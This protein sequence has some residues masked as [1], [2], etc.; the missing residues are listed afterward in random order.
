MSFQTRPAGDA[1]SP[2]AADG[3][4]EPLARMNG[5]A[6]VMDPLAFRARLVKTVNTAPARVPRAMQISEGARL[7]QSTAGSERR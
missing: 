6:S 4:T 1:G 3:E 2:L 7:L 5:N